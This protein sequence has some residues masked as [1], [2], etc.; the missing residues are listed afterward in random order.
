MIDQFTFSLAISA[1]INLAVQNFQLLINNADEA[2]KVKCLYV[3][4]II[5]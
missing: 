4:L 5:L 1:E 2:C 3:E